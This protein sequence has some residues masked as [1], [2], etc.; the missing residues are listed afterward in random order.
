MNSW[1]EEGVHDRNRARSA[2]NHPGEKIKTPPQ[3]KEGTMRRQVLD[4]V[5]SYILCTQFWVKSFRSTCRFFLSHFSAGIEAADPAL[6]DMRS[7]VNGHCYSGINDTQTSKRFP[8]CTC[9][10]ALYSF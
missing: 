7:S 2:R 9:Y 3:E 1:H 10:G 4:Y 6:R 8:S 5:R